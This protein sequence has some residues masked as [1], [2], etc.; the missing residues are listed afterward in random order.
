M[1]RKTVHRRIPGQGARKWPPTRSLRIKE[2][3]HCRL[4]PSIGKMPLPFSIQ[5]VP[6]YSFCFYFILRPHFAPSNRHSQPGSLGHYYSRTIDSHASTAKGPSLSDALSPS[7]SASANV[8]LYLSLQGVSSSAKCQHISSATF[9]QILCRNFPDCI[10]GYC[11]CCNS[12]SLSRL[13]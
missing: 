2:K 8:Q 5:D 9:Q 10:Y 11:F 4:Y 1:Y 12:L 3:L 7:Q 6:F 13:P